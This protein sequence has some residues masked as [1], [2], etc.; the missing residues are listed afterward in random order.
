MF[1]FKCA[2]C[3]E[4]HEGMPSFSIDAP[5]YYLGMPEEQRSARCELTT[6]L[7][8]IDGEYFFARGLIEIPVQGSSEPFAWGVWVSL[9]N[10]SFAEFSDLYETSARDIYGPYFGWLSSQLSIY[11]DTINLAVEVHLR[12]NGVRPSIVLEPSNHPLSI[13]QRNGM[14]IERVAEIYAA[15]MHK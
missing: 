13:E 11:P 9:S 12:N 1:R 2:A 14:S 10:K 3:D 15:Y 5:C 8:V 7:C 6:D 4:W